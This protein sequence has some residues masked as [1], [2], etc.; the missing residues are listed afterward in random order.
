MAP[1]LDKLFALLALLFAHQN[2]YE[3]LINCYKVVI[4]YQE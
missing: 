1:Q 4:E 2:F 3:V